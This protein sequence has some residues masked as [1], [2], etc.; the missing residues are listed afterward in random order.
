MELAAF[1]Q[2]A[3]TWLAGPIAWFVILKVR[4]FERFEPDT[5]RYVAYGLSAVI[6]ALA[7]LGL[8]G[9]GKAPLPQGVVE[10]VSGLW[11]VMT[12]SFGLA[13]LLN[14]PSLTKYRSDAKSSG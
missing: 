10:S 13:T 6:A 8:I 1:L 5:K 2:A 4:W 11:L 9:I 12:A 3:S 14:G 7:W